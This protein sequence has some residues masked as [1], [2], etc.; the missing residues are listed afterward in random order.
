MLGTECN[1]GILMHAMRDLF[2][3]KKEQEK[4]GKVKIWISYLEIYNEILIDL[5][6]PKAEAGSLKIKE[7]S[8]VELP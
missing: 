5:L 4:Q 7:D 1:P 2:E 6:N 8:S 3:L